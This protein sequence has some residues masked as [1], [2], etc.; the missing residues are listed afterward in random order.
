MRKKTNKN[1]C[2]YCKSSEKNVAHLFQSPPDTSG[3]SCFICNECVNVIY[4]LLGTE[5]KAINLKQKKQ[6]ISIPSP[7]EIVEYLDKYV[8]GQSYAK[9]ILAVA[10]VN[11]CKR[12]NNQS[13]VELEK[14]N[15]LLVGPTGSGKTLL[16]KTL[17]K[18]LKLPFAIGDATTITEAGYVGED[19]ENLVL[20]LLIE[21]DFDVEAAQKGIIY[22]DEIDKI[23]KK[24]NNVSLTRDVSGEGVQQALLKMLEGTACNVPPSGGRK[25]P[26]QKFISVDTTNVLFICGGTFSGIESIISKR[27]G[28]KQI[29]FI[30]TQKEQ[31]DKSNLLTKV[32]SDDLIEFGMIPELIGRLPVVSCL[33]AMTEDSLISILTEPKNS[34]I[35]QYQKLCSIDD[36][37]LKFTDSSLREIAR[38]ALDKGTGARGLRSI[39]ESFMTDI[40]FEISEHKNKVLEI[41]DAIVVGKKKLFNLAA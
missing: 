26:E 39:M 2:D 32:T 33:S 23:G 24:T 8:I 29:G 25:H 10:V 4:N 6:S 34:I 16:A 15:I 35:K 37:E 22:I 11:H 19:V 5:Q 20:K 7:K 38:L 12:L 21:T 13:D 28:K 17:A 30:N 31:L 27:L 18:F 36:V 9:R 1:T 14:S 3:E 40:M 41:D